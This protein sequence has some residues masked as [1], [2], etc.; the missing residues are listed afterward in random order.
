MNATH[1]FVNASNSS[2]LTAS[3]RALCNQEADSA[4]FGAIHLSSP[5]EVESP[6]ENLTPAMRQWVATHI[7]GQRRLAWGEVEARARSIRV[8]QIDG[9]VLEIEKDRI[10]RNKFQRMADAVN[11]F[12][13][14]HRALTETIETLKRECQDIRQAEGGRDCKTTSLT[15]EAGI[16]LPL[17]LLPESFL[18]FGSI[19]LMPLVPSD[20]VALAITLFVGIA[21]GVAAH[22]LG[23]FSR[24][25][26]YY[27]HPTDKEKRATGYMT[28]AYGLT[29]FVL[30]IGVIS[31]ARYYYVVPRIQDAILRGMPVPSLPGSVASLLLGNMIALTVGAA[32][33]FRLNDPNEQYQEKALEL[34][35]RRRQLDKWR[36]RELTPVIEAA[37]ESAARDLQIAQNRD[38]QMATATGYGALRKLVAE[39]Q[40]EDAAIIGHLE[41][42]RGELA[43]A[44]S[45]RNPR[46]HF[47]KLM[48]ALDRAESSRDIDLNEFLQLDLRLWRQA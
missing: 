21:M 25:K 38:K 48:P 36:A 1:S 8:E 41:S 45:V 34:A 7:A 23:I 5:A 32:V 44:I 9:I 4:A 2:E 30:A 47:R 19:R 42:Y 12:T 28:L 13:L 33:A 37:V 31:V 11:A 35:K 20:F 16:L 17:I 10:E 43:R 22:M 14:R 15:F 29:A 18:N 3:L 39:T 6:G 40:A 24:R 26:R 27:M 46:F